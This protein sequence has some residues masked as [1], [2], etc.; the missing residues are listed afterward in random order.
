MYV[1]MYA[2]RRVIYFSKI[3]TIFSISEYAKSSFFTY[4]KL[5]TKVTKVI[6]LRGLSIK[7]F[8]NFEGA[9]VKISLN[10]KTKKGH[11]MGTGG[12]S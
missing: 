11:N 2:L 10:D 4:A 9:G 12:L 6:D 8:G 3:K 1:F 5:F 7:I